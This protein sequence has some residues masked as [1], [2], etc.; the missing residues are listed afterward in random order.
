[1]TFTGTTLAEALDDLT[2]AVR[3]EVGASPLLDNFLRFHEENPHIYRLIEQATLRLAQHRK[4]Y[5]IGAVIEGVRW[6]VA[7]GQTVSAD[8]FKVNNNHR[9]YYA[10]LFEHHH[11]ELAGFFHDRRLSRCPQTARE[12]EGRHHA[13]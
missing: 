10:R 7:T 9:A 11:Q 1:M 8:G 6:E 4:H 5:G 12:Q 13:A 2:A 3:L